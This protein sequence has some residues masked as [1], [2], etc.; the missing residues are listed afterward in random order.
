MKAEMLSIETDLSGQP[1][2]R[3]ASKLP[4]P[5][6]AR[7]AEADGVCQTLEGPVQY[8]AGDAILTGVRGEQWP[9]ARARF[10]QTYEADAV[11]GHYRKRPI[12]VWALPLRAP[13]EVPLGG[14]RGTLHGQPGD[15]LVQYGPGDFGIVAADIF[16]QTY[17]LL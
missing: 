5:V 8:A 1:A 14:G 6:Q 10:D 11:A 15:W 3:R 17:R 7:F 9:V 4:L 12:T 16:E 2:A 13:T